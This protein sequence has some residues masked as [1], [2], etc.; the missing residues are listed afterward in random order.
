MIHSI[1]IDP[2]TKTGISVTECNR[3]TGLYKS[4][5]R[6]ILSA[7]KGM[8]GMERANHISIEVQ[9]MVQ[10]SRSSLSGCD[11]IK[12]IIVLEGYGFGHASSIQIIA[13]IGT[14]IRFRLMQINFSYIEV[15]PTA[16][17]KFVT[18]KGNAKKDLMLMEVYKRWGIECK[19]H[20]EADAFGLSMY[21]LAVNGFISVPKAHLDQ[22]LIAKLP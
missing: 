12:P 5:K 9:K 8:V 20:D 4:L 2:S 1:G 11:H 18:G 10:A 13:E 22:K 16:L 21:G 3:E 17:K 15:A 14:L 7:P 19:T 6:E